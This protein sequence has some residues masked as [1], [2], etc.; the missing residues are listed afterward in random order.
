VEDEYEKAVESALSEKVNSFI[1]PSFNDIE[2]AIASLKEKGLGRTAFIAVS[3]A[4]GEGGVETIDAPANSM[5][6][7]LSFIKTR[8]EFSGVAKSLLKISL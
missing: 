8:E 2:V 3:P 7:A 1:L 6:K 4:F 5:G